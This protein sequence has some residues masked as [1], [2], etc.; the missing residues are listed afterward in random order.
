[1]ERVLEMVEYIHGDRNVGNEYIRSEEEVK[2]CTNC[3][4]N[5][6]FK[7]PLQWRD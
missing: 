7:P 1:M 6:C 3:T 5:P 4:N 2:K